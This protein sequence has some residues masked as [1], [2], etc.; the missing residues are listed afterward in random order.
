ME[1]A[2]VQRGLQ[3]ASRIL[4]DMVLAVP[5]RI[6]AQVVASGDAGTAQRLMHAELRGAL[7]QFSR[8]AA[9]GLSKVVA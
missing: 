5:N 4:R 2:A 6:A 8:L 1:V 9:D 3:E 7:E